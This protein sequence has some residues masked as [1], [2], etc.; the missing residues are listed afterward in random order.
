MKSVEIYRNV[1]G[2]IIKTHVIGA[3]L[4]ESLVVVS[5]KR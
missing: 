3:L 5:N 2:V 1:D 4:L